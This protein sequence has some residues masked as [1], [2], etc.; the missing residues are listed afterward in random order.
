MLRVVAVGERAQER[1]Q[2][3]DLRGGERRRVAAGERGRRIRRL[4][5]VDVGIERYRQVVVLIQVRR[6]IRGRVEGAERLVGLGSAVTRG[7]A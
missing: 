5:D 7:S 3:I 1:H 6:A 4:P 2:V